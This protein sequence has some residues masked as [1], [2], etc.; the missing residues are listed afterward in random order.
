MFSNSS[1][2]SFIW[3]TR[4]TASGS[5]LNSS[6]IRFSSCSA[7]RCPSCSCSCRAAVALL[8]CSRAASR[9]AWVSSVSISVWSRRLVVWVYWSNVTELITDLMPGSSS[10]AA[11][12]FTEGR[13]SISTFPFSIKA[14]SSFFLSVIFEASVLSS[15]VKFL[16]EALFPDR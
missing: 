12:A 2:A 3:A 4:A 7:A 11:S 10:F 9:S 14:L 8:S 5:T 16:V 15:S 1:S 13:R 6:S